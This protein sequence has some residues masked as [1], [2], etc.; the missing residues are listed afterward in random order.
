MTTTPT[1]PGTTLT[2]PAEQDVR[3]A[4][5]QAPA[6]PAPPPT[7]SGSPVRSRAA[8]T[9]WIISLLV[10]VTGMFMSVLDVSIVNVAIPSMQKDFGVT[11]DD[12]QWVSTA[13]SLALGVIVP[14]SAWLGERLGLGRAYVMSLIGFGLGSALC[15]LAW[16][17]NSMIVFRILQAIPGGII[18]V[19]ALSMVYQLVPR[20][21]IGAAMGLYG[22][23]IV[24]APAV[25]PTLGGYLVEYVDWRLIFFI[26]VPV[27]IVGAIAALFLLPLPKGT[28]GKKFDVLGFVAI[29]SGL[30]SLLLA[31]SEGES[32][33]WTSYRVMILFTYGALALATFVVIEL[34]VDQPLLNVRVFKYW[35]FTN[36]LLLI[37]VLSVGLFGVLFFIPLFLQQT[38]DLGAFDTGLL[39]LP[40][41][42]VMGVLM[43]I[44]GRIYDRFGPR[45]PAVVGLTI[46]AIGTWM[47]HDLSTTTPWSD[48]RWILMFRACGM[49][50]AMMPIMTG[51]IS[52]VP[53][54]HVTG[55]SA[56]NNVTQRTASAMGLAALTALLSSKEAQQAADVGGMMGLR[57]PS[58]G[59]AS[60]TASAASSAAS[61]A[62]SGG[63]SPMLQQYMSYTQVQSDAFVTGLDNL[64][65][66]TAALTAV[67]VVLALFLRN[68][69]AKSSGGPA[70][71]EA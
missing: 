54:E 50:L 49:G 60:S 26:N 51:G 17:L 53:P 11:T 33:G 52:A 71:V 14:V 45:I 21:R 70:V 37:T 56:F 19:V 39:L 5:P 3:T 48:L 22:L 1:A 29:A 10:L 23:G 18:P 58:S 9:P 38:Q 43:P 41:A 27:G 7:P 44:A 59:A 32:W 35:A 31:L 16:D 40:Q 42:L 64:M 68:G 13:Y 61:G 30:F 62:S 2:E 36:S 12:I 47:L 69:P 63:M 57:S 28:K 25:G 6:P 4:P 55:A 46:L 34:E 20:E 24:F 65:I 8:S 15:G 67:G 66:V